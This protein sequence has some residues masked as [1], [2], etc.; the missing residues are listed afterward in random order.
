M[1]KSTMAKEQCC[2]MKSN[3]VSNVMAHRAKPNG[4]GN[5]DSNGK[6]LLH[7]LIAVSSSKRQV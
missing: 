7:R 6:P 3:T 1:K 2:S 5:G 4:Y